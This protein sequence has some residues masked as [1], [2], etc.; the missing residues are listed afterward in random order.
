MWLVRIIHVW[1]LMIHNIKIYQPFT[2]KKLWLY[3][4]PTPSPACSFS[5]G[6]FPSWTVFCHRITRRVGQIKIIQTC[7]LS[8]EVLYG[9]LI[10]FSWLTQSQSFQNSAIPSTCLPLLTLSTVLSYHVHG[11]IGSGSDLVVP[12]STDHDEITDRPITSTAKSDR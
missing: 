8:T 7:K 1:L 5:Y 11:E 6:Y 9:R 3:H 4:R 10:R 12:S 2:T